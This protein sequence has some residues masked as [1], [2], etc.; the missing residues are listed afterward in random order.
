MFSI[1]FLMFNVDVREK[2]FSF[3]FSFNYSAK[4]NDKLIK[5]AKNSRRI[6]KNIFT[7]DG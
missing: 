2:A 5:T 4:L 7:N 6:Y 3:S 1:S